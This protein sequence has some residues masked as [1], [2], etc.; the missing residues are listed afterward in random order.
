LKKPTRGIISRKEI[1][2]LRVAVDVRRHAA[3]GTPWR[4]INEAT[5]GRERLWKN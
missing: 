4:A 3:L 2:Q 5:R 1:G